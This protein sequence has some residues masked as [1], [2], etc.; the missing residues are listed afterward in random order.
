MS[1]GWGRR[2]GDQGEALGGVFTAAA[3]APASLA[4]LAGALAA[5]AFAAGLCAGILLSVAF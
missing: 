5:T 2:N 3:P 1:R 4:G